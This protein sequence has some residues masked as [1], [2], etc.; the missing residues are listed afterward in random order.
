MTTTA[1]QN[2]MQAELA[3]ARAAHRQDVFDDDQDMTGDAT[4]S[5]KRIQ[6]GTLVLMFIVAGFFDLLG[7]FITIYMFT[8]G[9]PVIGIVLGA[10]G[11]VLGFIIDLLAGTIFFIWLWKL[12]FPLT[13]VVP[14]LLGLAGLE[15]FV[16]AIPG[17]VG[18]VIGFAIM[19]KAPP[20]AAVT[21]LAR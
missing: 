21:R 9:I 20:V 1:N 17:W 3:R 18:L 16:S 11:F 13:K 5:G 14:A 7:I 12:G 2:A 15:F 19:D 6:I 4:S 10:F 8:T